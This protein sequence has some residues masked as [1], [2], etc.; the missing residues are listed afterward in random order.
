MPFWRNF[1]DHLTSLTSGACC[2]GLAKG[3]FLH[4]HTRFCTYNGL[5]VAGVRTLSL[6]KQKILE[7]PKSSPPLGSLEQKSPGRDRVEKTERTSP[8]KSRALQASRT[9]KHT[10]THTHTHARTHAHTHTHTHTTQACSR[11]LCTTSKLL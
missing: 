9:T 7:G 6:V 3:F 4:I 2:G 5:T 10:H 11:G 8:S 1:R